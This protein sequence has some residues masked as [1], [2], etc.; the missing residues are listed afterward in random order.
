MSRG[1]QMLVAWRG[2]ATQREAAKILGITNV[3]F[4]RFEH[5]VR[6]PSKELLF[7]IEKLTDGAVPAASWFQPP[8][9]EAA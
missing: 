7:S 3:D 6:K 2:A 5:G 4:S 8:L 9:R 1:A